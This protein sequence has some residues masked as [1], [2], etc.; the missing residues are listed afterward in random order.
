MTQSLL[1]PV[2]V[3]TQPVIVVPEHA[4]PSMVTLHG[5]F[6]PSS[7]AGDGEVPGLGAV[8]PVRAKGDLALAG[9]DD[10][11]GRGRGARGRGG[12]E[13]DPGGEAPEPP[14]FIR[15]IRRAPPVMAADRAAH[16]T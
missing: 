14:A 7:A 16:Q 4:E 3:I 5:M 2:A 1:H 9:A 8:G 13:L 12:E 6:R 10:E 15:C 11:G